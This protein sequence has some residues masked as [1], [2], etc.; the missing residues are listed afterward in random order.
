MILKSCLNHNFEVTS[1]HKNIWIF[2]KIQNLNEWFSLTLA[3]IPSYQFFCLVGKVIA[4]L[5]FGHWLIVVA[6]GVFVCE[7]F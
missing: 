5:I 1:V 7:Y 6:K 2:K 4:P 3:I